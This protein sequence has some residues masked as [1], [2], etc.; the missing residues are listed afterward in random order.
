[1]RNSVK[2]RGIMVTREEL[3]EALK[4]LDEPENLSMF[5]EKYGGRKGM[6]I[7]GQVQRDYARGMGK[8]T[9]VDGQGL[10]YTYTSMDQLRNVW[11]L[12]K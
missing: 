4:A 1:M 12:A 3:H 6:L 8:Y 7:Y 2:I 11:E 10:G 9:I 5:T